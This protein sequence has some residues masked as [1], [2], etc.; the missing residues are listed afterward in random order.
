[1]KKF[2]VLLSLSF[3][4]VTGFS[5]TIHRDDMSRFYGAMALDSTSSAH[6]K[7]IMTD[8]FVEWFTHSLTRENAAS[9]Y[10]QILNKMKTTNQYWFYF[11]NRN[12]NQKILLN[13][14]INTPP[15]RDN[16]EL[17]LLTDYLGFELK[18]NL[19]TV[20]EKIGEDS[21]RYKCGLNG[22]FDVGIGATFLEDAAFLPDSSL[23]L[24]VKSSGGDAGDW[25]G[26]Y[27]FLIE[28]G[29]CK[30]EQFYYKSWNFNEGEFEDLFTLSY[31]I[32]TNNYNII[33]TIEYFHYL[34]DKTSG[35]AGSKIID[36]S[37]V[38]TLNLLE[39]MGK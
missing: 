31:E 18:R 35:M 19:L 27:K 38:D 4:T 36:S 16:E 24:I 11:E 34:R 25:W 17:Y 6:N 13:K 7:P 33:E 23:V 21:L 5:Q 28:S 10:K 3:L 30:F 14:L 22:Q 29:E 26:N 32:D 37:S 9:L 20:W 1:M 8:R 12:P 15:A 39:I 2:I